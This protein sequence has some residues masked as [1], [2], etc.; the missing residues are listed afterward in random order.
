MSGVDEDECDELHPGWMV[1][2]KRGTKR[3]TVS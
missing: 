1:D 3:P 2:E